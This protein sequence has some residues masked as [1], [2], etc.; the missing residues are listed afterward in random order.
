MEQ[1]IEQRD[2]QVDR[3]AAEDGIEQRADE[4]TD[5]ALPVRLDETKNAEI[6]NHALTG[7]R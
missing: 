7:S 6:N 4:R 5:H 2:E 3:N 1:E